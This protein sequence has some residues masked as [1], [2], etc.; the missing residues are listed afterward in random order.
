MGTQRHSRESIIQT[1]QNVAANLGTTKLSSRD[2]N[3]HIPLSAVKYH[4]GNVG[5]ALEAAG[6]TGNKPGPPDAIRR[7]RI[8]ESQ[9]FESLLKIEHTIG[10]APTLSES[11][12]SGG[13]Y[14]NGPFRS[15]FGG[16]DSV[17]QHYNRWKVDGEVVT[18]STIDNRDGVTLSNG[19][20]TANVGSQE[21][22]QPQNV[23]GRQRKPPQLFGEPIDFRGLRHAP[24]NEQG[25]VYLF[26]MV[27]RELGFSVEALQQGFPD[28]EGKYLHDKNRKLWAKSRIEFEFRAS[29][30]RQHGHNEDDCDVIVCWETIGPTARCALSN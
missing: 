21:I 6:L 16:W 2:V 3:P 26:G 19:D 11:R 5:R 10:H 28:C 4:F 8:P 15:R 27:S 25:V 7:S 1:L 23:V 9:L 13:D 17:L 22:D 14:S 12:A 24:I 20:A 18:G 30:F 29:N